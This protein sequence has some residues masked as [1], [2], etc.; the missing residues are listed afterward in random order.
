[1]AWNNRSKR[2][3]SARGC[4][5]IAR[6]LVLISALAFPLPSSA[7]EVQPGAVTAATV[8][9][10]LQH[11]LATTVGPVPF[12]V[13]MHE[14]V[15]AT[16]LI[17]ESG[18]ISAPRALKA[19]RLYDELTSVARRTQAPVR[20]WLDA[21]QLPYRAFYMV[22]MIKVQGDAQSAEALRHLPGV[23]RLAANPTVS[24]ELMMQMPTSDRLRP[25]AV[26]WAEQS[27]TLPDGIVFSNAPNVWDL[28]Y[29]GQGIIIASQD[30]GVEWDHPALMTHYRGV[31]SDTVA[32]TY[33][34][35]H[36]YNWFDAYP[37]ASR[38]TRCD[39]NPQTPCD[40]HGH[41]TH[42]VGTML[43]DASATGGTIIGMAPGA[44]W[45]GCRNM[46]HGVG[47]PES[48]AACFEF[49]LAP[50]P[51]GGDPL[52]DGRPE[53]GPDIIN[54]SWGCP[55][56]EGCEEPEV[57][58]QVVENAR[59]AGQLVVA[60]A[61]N[62]GTRCSGVED[63]IAIYDAVFSVGAHDAVGKIAGFSSRGPVTIDGSN[64]LKPDI[65]APGVGVRSATVGRSYSTL[66][67]TSMAAPHVAGAV[68]L[69][70]SAA[71][72]LKGQIDLTEQVL[73]KSTKAPTVFPSPQ[74]DGGISPVKP[75]NTFGYGLLDVLAA[76][77]MAQQPLTLTVQVLDQAEAPV[78]GV[79]I[80]VT[81]QLTGYPYT[82]LT[83]VEGLAAFPP[84]F[85]GDYQVVTTAGP[86]FD[87]PVVTLQNGESRQVVIKELAPVEN[88]IWYLP[89]VHGE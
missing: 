71:P 37:A 43:G 11:Q 61:G 77:Q 83:G 74:C 65:A 57:L 18:L 70:W 46:D 85:A 40:D 63:P 51:Q 9:E 88:V 58:R 52:T 22:N 12:L 35:D 56:E 26:T 79:V 87:T 29:T 60:S 33:T 64:R 16:A 17:R 86:A 10:H 31:I 84:L 68:A 7:Q 81:D 13:I 66:S 38:P 80:T 5:V 75:N 67:G 24:G 41:G 54:N 30:T 82:G 14:Q 27:Q 36:V 47:T 21:H 19:R 59:A 69:L 49:F 32:M 4:F 62:N 6:L 1:M 2:I 8:S 15:D 89:W 72:A 44:Q 20:A 42:T 53:L 48:Y 78:A 23:A 55:K 3:S 50:Y 76:V 45:I 34:I 25:L 73:I 39:P 28:G